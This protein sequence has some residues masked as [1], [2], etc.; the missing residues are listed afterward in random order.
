VAAIAATMKVK[1]LTVNERGVI[2]RLV[3]MQRWQI[4]FDA[5][6]G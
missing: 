2:L 1:R 6:W 4:F 3:V 5:S